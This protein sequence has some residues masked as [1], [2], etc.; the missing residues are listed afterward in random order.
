MGTTIG[1]TKRWR[2]HGQSMDPP[3]SFRSHTHACRSVV[4]THTPRGG[5]VPPC[6]HAHVGAHG[7]ILHAAVSIGS[8]HMLPAVVGSGAH[9]HVAAV[10]EAAA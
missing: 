2:L 7:R 5:A 1:C 8:T 6:T 10:D 9:G 3:Q 4:M